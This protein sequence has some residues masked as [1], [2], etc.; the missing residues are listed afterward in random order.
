[1]APRAFERSVTYLVSDIRNCGFSIKVKVYW[2]VEFEL[3]EDQIC[4]N[5]LMQTTTRN[6]KKTR[7]KQG[8]LSSRESRVGFTL[9]EVMISMA[10]ILTI[11]AGGFGALFQG[12]KLVEIARDETRAS[13][14]LQSEIE[15]LRTLDWATLTALDTDAAYAAK[16]SF[17]DAY[18]DR[19]SI[20]RKITTR[21]ATERRVTLTVTWTD[22]RGTDHSREYITLIAKDGLY[23]YYYRSF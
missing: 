23:D 18:A 7:C 20:E 5:R 3:G 8:A 1:M 17:T 15:D 14:V 21:S 10:V 12:N 16:S 4:L 19:Y 22:N 2:A 9:V 13:Q 6:S 11:F